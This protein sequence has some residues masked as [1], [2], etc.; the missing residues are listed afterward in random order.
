MRE[1]IELSFIS[2]YGSTVSMHPESRYIGKGHERLFLIPLISR[3][4]LC[5]GCCVLQIDPHPSSRYIGLPPSPKGRLISPIVAMTKRSLSFIPSYTSVR[6]TN[7]RPHIPFYQD[8][9]Y[10][11]QA[12][13]QRER[14][15]S[16]FALLS[17]PD[18]MPGGVLY[19]VFAYGEVSLFLSRKGKKIAHPLKNGRL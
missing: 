16:L 19:H 18:I 12:L 3:V 2:F 9:N 4:S 10:S 8:S 13:R 15:S 17:Q 5:R 11:M 6:T 7:G 1:V 14:P